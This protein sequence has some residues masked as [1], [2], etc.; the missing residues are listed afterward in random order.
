MLVACGAARDGDASIIDL[1]SPEEFD[2][3]HLVSST[4]LP[5]AGIKDRWF[6]MP[7]HGSE[8]WIVL[9]DSDADS[10]W[11]VVLMAGHSWRV[12]AVFTPPAALAAARELGLCARGAVS[13]RLWRP[14]PLLELVLPDVERALLADGL[15]LHA[16]DVGC[17]SG[18]DCG[19]LLLHG[20]HVTGTDR[21]ARA[22]RRAEAFASRLLQSASVAT[23]AAKDRCRG[24]A[25]FL[26]VDLKRLPHALPR[27]AYTLVHAARFLHRPAFAAVRQ[28]VAPG[29]FVCWHTFF[30]GV[31]AF[32]HPSN[33][34]HILQPGELCAEFGPSHGFTV[35]LD[36]VRPLHDGRPATYFMAKSA[37]AEPL[38][39]S[40]SRGGA[41]DGTTQHAAA[42][43]VQ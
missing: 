17:G 34:G 27:A 30:S 41:R 31:E 40:A 14:S 24:T 7:P 4:N 16:L 2:N 26:Q 5:R 38:P 13:R 18:R 43:S 25:E 29:G 28:A 15:E 37:P 23:A 11:Q 21:C 20:W 3:E 22:L 6:E 35:L 1:R 19:F 42:D 8:L 9:D 39:H 36:V 33:P 12:R 10:A 32:G